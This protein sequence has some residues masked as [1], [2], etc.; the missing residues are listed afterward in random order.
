MGLP[1]FTF[2]LGGAASGKTAF[3]EDAVL[4]SGR[5]PV[6][7][8]TAEARDAEMAARIAAHRS[9]R[10]PRWRTL[11][12]PRD[13]SGALATLREGEAV[14][15][16]CA[17]LWLSNLILADADLPAAEEAL[18]SAIAACPAPVVLVSN[19]V[20]QGIVPD[21]PLARRFRDAQGGLN[22]RMAARAD[23][24]IAVMAGLPLVLKGALP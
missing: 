18:L 16:D 14:V 12:A 23:A 11:E 20:G 7:I 10:G 17:T 22:R 9:A 6:Y 15:I 24:V 2:V 4:R 1:A 3:A 5:A 8:A 13:L 19:E 21:N